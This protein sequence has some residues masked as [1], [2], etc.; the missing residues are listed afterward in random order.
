M[1]GRKL[2]APITGP[3]TSTVTMVGPPNSGGYKPPILEIYRSSYRQRKPYDQPLSFDF[4]QR[5]IFGYKAKTDLGEDTAYNQTISALPSDNS[6]WPELYQKV[7][8][9][10]KERMAESA[11]LGVAFA[12]GREAMHMIEHRL[13]QLTKFS[14][15]LLRGRF[16]DA[17]KALGCGLPP[18][19]GRYLSD[20]SRSGGLRKGAKHFANNYLEF[21]FGWAPLMSDIHDAAETLS[22]PIIPHNVFAKARRFRA[23]VTTKTHY[24]D[25][26]LLSDKYMTDAWEQTITLR[27]QVSV[28]NPNLGLSQQLGMINPLSVAWELVPYSFVLDWFVNVGEFLQQF[29]DFAGVNLTQQQRTIFTRYNGNYLEYDKYNYNSP[30]AAYPGDPYWYYHRYNGTKW[31]AGRTTMCTRILGAFP[32]PSLFIRAPWTL[33]PRRGL[34]AASLL[35]QRMK[36]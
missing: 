23:P 22:S 20:T 25:G 19:R 15:A 11:Q 24:D 36:G 6:A 21:H 1:K 4:R 18:R 27:A 35:I 30:V 32:G 26:S 10:F 34:A 12:E 31:W 17:A 13:L 16:G 28:T 3:F 33:S 8:N 14:H 2:T 29:T 7:Y 9:K 5:Y